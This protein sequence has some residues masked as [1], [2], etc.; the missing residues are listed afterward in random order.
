MIIMRVY[1]LLRQTERYCQRC[2]HISTFFWVFLH[3]FLANIF[4]QTLQVRE[5]EGGMLS[6]ASPWPDR[7]LNYSLPDTRYLTALQILYG[8]QKSQWKFWVRRASG[9]VIR[10]DVADDVGANVVD[11]SRKG[12][13]DRGE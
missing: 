9:P 3:L 12:S 10:R 4:E 13:S 5:K 6:G 2:L 11:I 1:Y 8:T 7:E